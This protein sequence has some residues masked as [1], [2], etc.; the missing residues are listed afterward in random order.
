MR[1]VLLLGYLNDDHTT[2]E[3]INILK[4]FQPPTKNVSPFVMN[5]DLYLLDT[6]G[7]MIFTVKKD[8]GTGEYIA[9]EVLQLRSAKG[10]SSKRFRG[11]TSPV[12]L[13]GNTWGYVVHDVIYNDS[14]TMPGSKLSYVHYW[15]EADFSRGVITFISS[16]FWC[17][18]WGIEFIS[19]IRYDRNTN[20]INLYL[21][22]KDELP[23]LC[24]CTLHD[25]RCG[26]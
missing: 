14:S 3:H 13:H 26:K 7:S 19:G 5:G 22:I 6:F 24:T 8:E 15:V 12:H 23:S 16:P 18:H 4:N 11:S 21:G 17:M 20:E 9:Q 1:N 10:I 2:I 25:L